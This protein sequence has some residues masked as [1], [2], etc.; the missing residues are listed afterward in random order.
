[1]DMP[2]LKGPAVE[3]LYRRGAAWLAGGAL[4]P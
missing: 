1:M 3:V 2:M 4:E